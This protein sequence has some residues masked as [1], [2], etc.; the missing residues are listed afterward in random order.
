MNIKTKDNYWIIV[1]TL[2]KVMINAENAKA[3]AIT[4]SFCK[5]FTLLIKNN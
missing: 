1:P 4:F 3:T 2:V 5:L